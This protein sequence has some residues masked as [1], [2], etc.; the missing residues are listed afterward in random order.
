MFSH[1]KQRS[2]R[3]RTK[4]RKTN[5]GTLRVAGTATLAA[6]ALGGLL[7]LGLEY[8]NAKHPD[9]FGC[10]EQPNQHQT[11]ILVDYSLTGQS[12]TQFRDY[13]NGA[14][15]QYDR[16]PANGRINIALSARGTHSNLIQPVFTICKPAQTEAEQLALGLPIE[17]KLQRKNKSEKARQQFIAKM[18]GIIQEAREQSKIA[19]NSP[20]LEFV[21]ALS[22][23]PWF[24]GTSR[25]LTYITD[26][27]QHSRIGYFCAQKGHMP[28]FAT[29]TKKAEYHRLKPNT[30]EGTNVTLLMVEIGEMPNTVYPYCSGFEEVRV[31]WENYFLNNGADTVSIE[32]LDYGV[33]D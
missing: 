12:N 7:Y 4:N 29:F 32:A 13:A 19:G 31:W 25:S 14:L 16:T 26:G 5:S 18:A 28:S 23:A 30:F 22:R 20:L 17:G 15:A 6:T 10:Y 21:R 33:G 3:S 8:S 1:K 2:R 11:A 24:Q 27:I 9:E